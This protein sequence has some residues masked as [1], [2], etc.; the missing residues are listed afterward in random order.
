MEYSDH[1]LKEIDP[2]VLNRTKCKKYRRRILLEPLDP[3][4][5]RRSKRNRDSQKKPLM[6]KMTIA[7]LFQTLLQSLR[8]KMLTSDKLFYFV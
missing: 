2:P 4:F 7:L 1:D 6:L 8:L 3:F 5:C